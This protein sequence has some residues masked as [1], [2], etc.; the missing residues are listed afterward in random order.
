[1]RRHRHGEAIDV[2]TEGLPAA[3]AAGRFDAA[4]RMRLGLALA[5]L[6]NGE[7][8]QALDQLDVVLERAI[9]AG[10]RRMFVD[11]PAAFTSLLERRLEQG[12]DDADRRAFV[13][14]VLAE[15]GGRQPASEAGSQHEPLSPGERRVLQLVVAGL[16][17]KE[18]G[19]R[20]F[21][22]QNTVKTHLRHIYA[23]TGARNRA[24]AIG[25]A[26]AQGLADEA[27]HPLESPGGA[28]GGAACRA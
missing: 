15:R 19:E 6:L 18:L 20:L 22:S 5:R 7:W 28:I 27:D 14:T 21:I 26:H 24:E 11:A 16:S 2:L 1:M 9:P 13:E 12:I 4:I 8:R 3:E 10:Y 23:K 25:Y 17:N